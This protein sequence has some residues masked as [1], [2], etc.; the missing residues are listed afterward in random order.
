[1]R[2]LPSTH[3]EFTVHDNLGYC[4]YRVEN[5]HLK[6]D[7]SGRV[8]EGYSRLS[9]KDALLSALFAVMWSFFR[10]DIRAQIGLLTAYA[11]VA[12]T[13][14]SQVLWESVIAIPPHGI[15]LET[16]CGYPSWPLFASKRFIPAMFLQDFIINEG[17]RRWDVRYYISAIQRTPDGSFTMETAYENILPHFPIL[18][19]VYRGIH[20]TDL[21][22]KD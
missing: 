9:W 6:R 17:L 15:Q 4:E 12:W 14:C 3:P 21:T 2:P 7:G 1:M 10:G 8:V 19:K 5:W 11:Y 20:Q 22:S 18:A 13:K 16:H